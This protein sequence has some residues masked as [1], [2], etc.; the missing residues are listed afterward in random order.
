MSAGSVFADRKL[1]KTNSKLGIQRC[2]CQPFA[3]YYLRH[4]LDEAQDCRY[5]LSS[6]SESVSLQLRAFWRQLIVH[7][8]VCDFS[9]LDTP[10]KERLAAK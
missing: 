6:N 9:Q 2:Y 4:L 7:Q 10:E 3:K 1:R 5:D 8:Y